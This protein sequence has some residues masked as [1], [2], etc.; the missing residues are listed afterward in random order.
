M[1]LFKIDNY[2]QFTFLALLNSYSV[3]K[4]TLFQLCLLVVSWLG[5]CS[6]LMG[7]IFSNFFIF[8]LVG[9]GGGAPGRLTIPASISFLFIFIAFFHKNTNKYYSWKILAIQWSE[10]ES[11]EKEGGS[12]KRQWIEFFIPLSF[13]YGFSI[14]HTCCWR[15]K[16]K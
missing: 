10:K 4:S 14:C 16:L 7:P 3:V 13:K 5:R 2:F 11:N 12:L 15:F 9:G 6:R 1:V 8:R